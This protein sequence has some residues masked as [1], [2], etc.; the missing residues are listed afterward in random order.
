VRG[1]KE[2]PFYTDLVGVPLQAILSQDE[3]LKIEERLQLQAPGGHLS[4]IQLAEGEQSPEELLS[5][6]KR[7][8]STSKIGFF[9]YSSSFAYCSRCRKTF[10][11]QQSKCPTCGSVDTLV[12]FGRVS[13]KYKVM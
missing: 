6:T 9:A 13:S 3:R 10:S 11:R 12:N 1:S 4:L 8:V 2:Q 5:V 7:L